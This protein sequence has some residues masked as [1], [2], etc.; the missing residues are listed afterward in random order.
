MQCGR[1]ESVPSVKIRPAED[2]GRDLIGKGAFELE[3]PMFET[4]GCKCSVYGCTKWEPTI[5]KDQ[6]NQV[7][8]AITFL[9]VVVK[10]PVTAMVLIQQLTTNNNRLEQKVLASWPCSKQVAQG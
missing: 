5:H 3:L 6:A 1:S 4:E 9:S 10:L 7:V 2:K 8:R